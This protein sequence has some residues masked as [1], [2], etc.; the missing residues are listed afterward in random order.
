METKDDFE[1]GEIVCCLF[2]TFSWKLALS[3]LWETCPMWVKS[4]NKR[5][6]DLEA[7]EIVELLVNFEGQSKHISINIFVIMFKFHIFKLHN[8]SLV[9]E[10]TV[11]FF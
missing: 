7:I 4:S 2:I 11:S 10:F 6:R 1:L 5:S 8:I 9:Q 3:T